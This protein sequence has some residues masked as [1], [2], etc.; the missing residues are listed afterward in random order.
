MS[1]EDKPETKPEPSGLKAIEARLAQL[2]AENT[3]LKNQRMHR[4]DSTDDIQKG[5]EIVQRA[6]DKHKGKYTWLV[7][8][9]CFDR[10][11]KPIRKFLNQ[12]E[13]YNEQPRGYEFRS[14]SKDEF[15]ARAEYAKKTG[16]EATNSNA[17]KFT[18][19]GA[20]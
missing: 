19:Q 2:E 13:G 15:Q 1:K 9:E 12:R 18:L 14:D 20:A 6:R 8:P 3:A 7:I 4:R 11:R 16:T 10:V 5:A 17:F